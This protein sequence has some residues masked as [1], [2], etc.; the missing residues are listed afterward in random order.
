MHVVWRAN[1]GVVANGVV[2]CPWTTDSWSFTLIHI[3]T[4]SGIFIQEVARGTAAL[5]TTEGVDAFAALAQPWKLLALVN[6]FQYNSDGVGPKTF[7]T[8]TKNFVLRGVHS[9]A[10]LTRSTPGFPQRTAAGSFGNTH[11]DFIA[12]G[13]IS[14]VSSRS[15]IQIAISRAGIDTANSSRIQLKIRWTITG[16]AAWSVDTVPTDTRGWIQT[17]INICAVP[18]TSVQFIANLTLTT[19]QARKIVTSSKNTDV[20]KG[21]LINIFAGFPVSTGHKAHV[22]FTAVSSRG[23]QAL[24]I[25]AQVQILRALIQIC[26]SEAIACVPFLTEAAVGAHGILAVCMLAAHVGSIGAFIQISALNA[27]SDPSGAAAAFEASCCVGTYGVSVAIVC[28][29]FTFIDV[30]TASFSF[31]A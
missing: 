27:I 5:E 30:C 9:R 12:T 19:E 4:H 20:W 15:N 6:V 25:A 24:A 18:T 11:S 14:I 16:I 17:F 28:S 10:K 31:F 8:R 1:A 23:V 26:A 22:A 7:S 21:A 3:I 2:T 29:D 13:S